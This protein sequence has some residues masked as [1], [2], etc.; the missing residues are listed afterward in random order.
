M[1]NSTPK[2]S[3]FVD[4]PDDL[5]I[6]VCTEWLGNNLVDLVHLDTSLCIKKQ[7]KAWL[8][9]LTNA[10]FALP[11]VELNSHNE[12]F[13]QLLAWL[14]KKGISVRRFKLKFFKEEAIVSIVSS[15]LSETH[16]LSQS[17]EALEFSSCDI[18]WVPCIAQSCKT[19]LKSLVFDNCTASTSSQAEDVEECLAF[20]GSE[21]PHLESLESTST[22]ITNK[23]LTDLAKGCKHLTSILLK[24]CAS[25]SDEGINSL[26]ENINGSLEKLSLIQCSKITPVGFHSINEVRPYTIHFT[27]YTTLHHTTPHYTTDML[28]EHGLNRS[29]QIYFTQ[30]KHFMT[31]GSS[32]PLSRSPRLR[33]SLSFRTEKASVCLDERAIDA[34]AILLLQL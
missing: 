5:L 28:Q 23:G 17:L 19:R 6:S 24:S 14:A 2:V 1:G 34:S 26:A 12:Y 9:V 25:I 13:S 32:S 11:E 18:R 10:A 27:R 7:R 33:K 29:S 21:C 31:S 22:N 30:F 16:V 3:R 8:S 4:Y 20:I 15:Y